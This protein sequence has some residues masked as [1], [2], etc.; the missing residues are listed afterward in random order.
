MLR[1]YKIW[2][3]VGIFVE[4]VNVLKKYDLKHR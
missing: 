4:E 1:N 3:A 2:N